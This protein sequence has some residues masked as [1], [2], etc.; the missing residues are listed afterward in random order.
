MRYNGQ[1]HEIEI[2][3]PGG[4]V[5]AETGV[6]LRAR[7]DA[8]YTHLFGRTLPDVKIE[9]LTWSLSVSTPE[10]SVPTARRRPNGQVAQP[11]G[12]RR[13][14][15]GERGSDIEVAAY[16]RPDLAPGC[17][18]DGPALV[19]ESQTTTVVPAAFGLLVDEAGNLIIERQNIERQP[20]EAAS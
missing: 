19:I 17:R 18:L 10:Q 8:R 5:T 4:E 16:W 2:P 1:G 3:V 15:D 13:L 14:F 7:Y 12:R 9:I 20:G 11:L 6:T